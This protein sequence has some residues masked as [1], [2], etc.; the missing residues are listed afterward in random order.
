M[1]SDFLIA[2]SYLNNSIK[3]SFTYLI[4][5]EILYEFKIKKLLN[6]IRIE[7]LNLNNLL[8]DI[9]STS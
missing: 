1:I 4:S 2:N 7:G 8:D 6:L 3:Y 9:K 5:T